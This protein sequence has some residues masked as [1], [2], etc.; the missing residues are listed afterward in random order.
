MS[1]YIELRG[2]R[3]N[4]LRD[5]SLRISSTATAAGRFE[6]WTSFGRTVAGRSTRSC[7]CHK[8]RLADPAGNEVDIA[9]TPPER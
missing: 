2:A 6:T 3:E 1:E 8:T 5:V 4:N 9:T 7:G